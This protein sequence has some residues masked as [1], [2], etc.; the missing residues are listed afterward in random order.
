MFGAAYVGGFQAGRAT[1]TVGRFLPVGISTPAQVV[2]TLSKGLCPNAE[3]NFPRPLTSQLHS[4][5]AP[6]SP[7][8]AFSHLGGVTGTAARSQIFGAE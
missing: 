4:P 3:H 1:L 5:S 8:F 6:E 2:I 7:P